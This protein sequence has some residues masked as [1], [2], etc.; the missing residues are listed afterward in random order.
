[1][2]Y[3]SWPDFQKKA[4][5]VLETGTAYHALSFSLLK[6]LKNILYKAKG[7]EKSK[8]RKYC[9]YED[10]QKAELGL[11]LLFKKGDTWS[12]FVSLWE[13]VWFSRSI[14]SLAGGAGIF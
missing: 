1:M 5:L 13:D 11:L 12:N 10:V 9:V 4:E 8:N 6:Y 2:C 14:L 3:K 7:K